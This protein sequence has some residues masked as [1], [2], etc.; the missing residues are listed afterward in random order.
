MSGRIYIYIYILLN[1]TLNMADIHISFIPMS[2]LSFVC[3]Q[4][5]KARWK[6]QKAGQVPENVAIHGYCEGL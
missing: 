2:L 5:R 1:I 4:F 3:L 6:Q